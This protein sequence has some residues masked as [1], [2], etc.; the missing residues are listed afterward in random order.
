MSEVKVFW[1]SY[2]Q[3]LYLIFE[4]LTFVMNQDILWFVGSSVLFVGIKKEV[5]NSLIPPTSHSWGNDSV[6][7]LARVYWHVCLQMVLY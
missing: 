2:S 7:R 4:L 5:S 1:R 3:S 6:F